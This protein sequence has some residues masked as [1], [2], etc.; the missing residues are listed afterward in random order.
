MICSARYYTT[1]VTEG[2]YALSCT[3]IDGIGGA[4][5]GEHGGVT[6]LQIHFNEFKN[7]GVVMHNDTD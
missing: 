3:W 7:M 2:G 1:F 5:P 6:G 4:D